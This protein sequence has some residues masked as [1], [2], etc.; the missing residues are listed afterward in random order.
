L[1]ALEMRKCNT[2]FIV[3][4]GNRNF[5]CTLHILPFFLEHIHK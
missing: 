5:G 1:K 2:Q 4:E 3:N